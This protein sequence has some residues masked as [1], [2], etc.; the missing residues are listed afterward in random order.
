MDDKQRKENSTYKEIVRG[1]SDAFCPFRREYQMDVL[2]G[3]LRKDINGMTGQK[4]L[5]ACCGQGRLL[6]YLY[7]FDSKQFYTGFDYVPEFV[8]DTE[9]LFK[10]NDSV[11]CVVADIYNLPASMQKAFDISILYK[12]LAW[13]PNCAEVLQALFSVTRKKLYI[14]TPLYAGDIDFEI[15]AHVHSEVNISGSVVRS[16]HIYG[17]PRF[18]E[19]CIE[20]GAEAVKIHDMNLPF[21]L[22][23][24]DDLNVLQT[25]TIETSQ[26]RYIEMTNIIKLDWKL[27][28]IEL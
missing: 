4:I 8:G 10:G 7:Q 24:P 14:T 5:D 9:E 27:V 12:T 11:R 1:M 3:F 6:Y 15:Q 26:K 22:P 28:E 23:E 13:I 16:H 18:V 25:Y 20:L 21:P 17:I 19:L 2:E